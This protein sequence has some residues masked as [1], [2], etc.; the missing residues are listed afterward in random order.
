MLRDGSDRR[1]ARVLQGGL[2]RV[3]RR[4]RRHG[5]RRYRRQGTQLRVRRRSQARRA[6]GVRAVGGCG[7]RPSRGGRDVQGLDGLRVRPLAGVAVPP[8]GRADVRR[9]VRAASALQRI[10]H[11]DDRRG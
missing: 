8:T 10:V 5:R 3:P 1:G 9:G 6:G 2:R 4:V 11:R 7:G